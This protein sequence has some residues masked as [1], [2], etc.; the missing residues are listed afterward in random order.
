M[1]FLLSVAEQ[2]M[3]SIITFGINIWLI[4]NG[5]AESYGVYVFWYSVAWV[6]ATCQSTLTVVHLSSLPSGSDRLAE[7][8]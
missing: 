7:R 5:A 4:R 8:R 1:R 6:L 3:G 2:G